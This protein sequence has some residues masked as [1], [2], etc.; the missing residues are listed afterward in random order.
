MLSQTPRCVTKSVAAGRGEQPPSQDTPA[1]LYFKKKEKKRKEK[2]RREEKRREEKRREEK[3]RDKTRQGRDGKGRE[4]TGREGKGREGKGREGK[5][6]EGKGREGKERKG[7]E[8]KG[9]ERKGK[10]GLRLS[11]SIQREA[12]NYTR[13]PR[14][15]ECSP[16]LTFASRNAIGSCRQQHKSVP[17]SCTIILLKNHFEPSAVAPCAAHF[18]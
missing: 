7:K 10:E 17:F 16:R 18:R 15:T 6:R 2:K 5:G 4:G 14:Y 1:T 3:R 13:L 9:K 11:A 8:R 12:K